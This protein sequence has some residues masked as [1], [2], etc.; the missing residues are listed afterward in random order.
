ML[1]LK[2]LQDRQAQLMDLQR[3]AETRLAE[4]RALN[5]KPKGKHERGLMPRYIKNDLKDILNVQS[6]VCH[7]EMY[8]HL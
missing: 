8:V 4:Q 2:T 3:H 7:I 1:Q 5:N 6:S